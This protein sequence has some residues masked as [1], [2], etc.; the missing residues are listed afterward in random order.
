MAVGVAQVLDFD[1]LL[2]LQSAYFY[3]L[4]GVEA[5]IFER[6]LDTVDHL[7][8][9]DTEHEKKRNGCRSRQVAGEV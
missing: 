1:G 4:Q 8:K 3:Q 9:L 7:K 2:L 5:A 6:I